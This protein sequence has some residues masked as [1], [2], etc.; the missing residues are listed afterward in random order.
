MLEK[1]IIINA[2]RACALMPPFPI[3]SSPLH[4]ESGFGRKS[5]INVE[6]VWMTVLCTA[7]CTTHSSRP[8][9]PAGDPPELVMLTP[10]ALVIVKR[11]R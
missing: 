3:S 9:S 7:T 6:L 2:S 5:S 10:R 1:C 11:A 4:T 8:A